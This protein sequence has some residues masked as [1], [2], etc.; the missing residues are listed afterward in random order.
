LDYAID[1]TNPAATATG[2]FE[3]KLLTD[4][5]MVLWQDQKDGGTGWGWSFKRKGYNP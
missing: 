5:L 4:D 1:C 2:V 3:I